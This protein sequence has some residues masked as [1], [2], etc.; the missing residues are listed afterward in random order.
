LGVPVST[1][2]GRLFKGR[3]QLQRAL[4]SVAREVLKPDHRPR[5]ELAMETPELVEVKID[6]VRT[7]PENEHRIVVLREAGADRIL[8]IWIGPPE[9]DSIAMA[10]EGRQPDRPMTHDL[11]LRLVETLGAQVQR[12]VVNNLAENTFYA[13]VTLAQG[14]QRHL[15][16]SRPSDAL[17]LAART[18]TPIYAARAILDTC[19]GPDDHAF[20]EHQ[21]DEM[22]KLQAHDPHGTTPAEAPNPT[23]E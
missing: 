22:R 5:K 10:L 20:W 6:S 18:G 7:D 21:R 8:P 3:R 17:A 13:E 15:V 23:T 16:D 19:G 1:V 12:V 4:E 11:T 2:K 14:A 9:A